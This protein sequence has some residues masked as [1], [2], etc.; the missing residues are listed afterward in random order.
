MGKVSISRALVAVAVE[1]KDIFAQL[2]DEKASA[3]LV[4]QHEEYSAVFIDENGYLSTQF[5][6]VMDEN[7]TPEEIKAALQDQQ[8]YFESRGGANWHDCD[9][10]ETLWH[11]QLIVAAET[12]GST[13]RWGLRQN[14]H[15]CVSDG[16]S[17][18]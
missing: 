6:E 8:L 15:Q 7:E 5:H 17:G 4:E 16:V 10:K 11:A 12:M 1:I 13:E 18:Y 2:G 14:G 3:L 9:E